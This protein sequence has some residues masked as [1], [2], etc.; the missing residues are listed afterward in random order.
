MITEY[1]TITQGKKFSMLK[2]VNTIFSNILKSDFLYRN[3]RII[4]KP[5]I[6][7]VYLLGHIDAILG[8]FFFHP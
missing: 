8:P 3:L 7:Q 6:N 2:S 4:V 1:Y 5:S